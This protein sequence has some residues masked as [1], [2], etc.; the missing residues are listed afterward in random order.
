MPFDV[1]SYSHTPRPET[2][3][4]IERI[5]NGKEELHSFNGWKEA[6]EWLNAETGTHADLF[7]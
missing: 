6:K 5:E 4:L 2:L 7:E 1:V 3:A